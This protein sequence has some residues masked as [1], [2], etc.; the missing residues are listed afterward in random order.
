MP[1]PLKWRKV[2]SRPRCTQFSPPQAEGGSVQMTVDEYE[3]IRLIDLEELTQEECARR[4]EVART[5]VQAIYQNARRKLANCIVNGRALTID[6]GEYR[7][8]ELRNSSCERG[9]CNRHCGKNQAQRE[10]KKL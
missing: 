10:D 5:T 8:C 9:C 4:M 1:R 2:C 3:T 6:G 7:T